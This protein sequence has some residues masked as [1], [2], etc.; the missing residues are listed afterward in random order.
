MKKLNF[1]RTK[2]L[3]FFDKIWGKKIYKAMSLLFQCFTL[4]VSRLTTFLSHLPMSTL[5]SVIIT[6]DFQILMR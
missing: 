2:E 6:N 1:R 4:L 5:D 3:K